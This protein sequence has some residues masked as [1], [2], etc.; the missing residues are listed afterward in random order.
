MR[1][2]QMSEIR[3]RVIG[4][5]RMFRFSTGLGARIEQLSAEL[6]VG[7]AA[8]KTLFL[9]SEGSSNE[10]HFRT[11]AFIIAVVLRRASLTHTSFVLS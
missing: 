11:Y 8:E 6:A 7:P 10:F 3:E 5:A 1:D 2:F 4:S 9:S